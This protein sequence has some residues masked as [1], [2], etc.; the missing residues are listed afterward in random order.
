MEILIKKERVWCSEAARTV[1]TMSGKT[2]LVREAGQVVMEDGLRVWE[3]PSRVGLQLCSE[4]VCHG[5]CL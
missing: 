5:C 2:A 3:T 4:G 1:T